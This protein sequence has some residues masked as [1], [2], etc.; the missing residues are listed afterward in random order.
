MKTNV[1]MKCYD[2]TE[3]LYLETDTLAVNLG[4]GLLQER[5]RMNC[6]EDTAPDNT[7]LRPIAFASNSLFSVETCY[8]NKSTKHPT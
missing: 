6:L 2:E 3:T 7:K 1:C 5:D 4:A 8:W